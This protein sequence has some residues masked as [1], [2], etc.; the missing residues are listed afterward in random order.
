M[1][2]TVTVTNLAPSV[3]AGADVTT[4][5]GATVAFAGQATDPSVVDQSSLQ[6]SWNFGDGSGT[7]PSGSGDASHV[8]ATPGANGFYYATL[9]VC[10]K[11][12]DCSSDVRRVSSS[13]RTYLVY[14]GDFIGRVNRDSDVRALLVDQSGTPLPGRTV[15]FQLGTQSVTATTNGYGLASTKLRPTQRGGLYALTAKWTPGGTDFGAYAGSSM[16]VP[17]LLLRR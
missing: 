6:Y 5:W 14:L 1:P 13:K 3:N 2:F 16:T 10:D 17:F 7:G 15:V 9:T 4:A 12:G 11:D 8:Y